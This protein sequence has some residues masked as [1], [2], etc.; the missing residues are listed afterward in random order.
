VMDLGSSVKIQ[1][2]NAVSSAEKF[3][4]PVDGK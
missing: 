4:I 1:E 2:K 3:K